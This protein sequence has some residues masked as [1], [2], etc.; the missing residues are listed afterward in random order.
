MKMRYIK[1]HKTG[2][3][4]IFL[5]LFLALSEGIANLLQGN[6]PTADM[7]GCYVVIKE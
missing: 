6:N 3:T 5:P 4:F 2:L 1:P 7:E